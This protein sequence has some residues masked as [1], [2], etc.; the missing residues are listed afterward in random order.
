L[1]L[2]LLLVG[3]AHLLAFYCWVGHGVCFQVVHGGGVH[4]AAVKSLVVVVFVQDEHVVSCEGCDL[5]LAC[6]MLW[7]VVD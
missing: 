3:L 4:A 7:S 2:L 1:L 6:A 5:C